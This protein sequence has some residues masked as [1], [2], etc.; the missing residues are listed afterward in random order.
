MSS[1]KIIREIRNL[2]KSINNQNKLIRQCFVKMS[3]SQKT[4]ELRIIL[5]ILFTD[6]PPVIENDVINRLTDKT[7]L[8]RLETRYD[9]FINKH[10]EALCFH[11]LID[12]VFDVRDSILLR[13][14]RV[15]RS[16]K[17]YAES[18]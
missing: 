14:G 2:T 10:Q 12:D 4:R 5:K 1:A 6:S 18:L 16:E 15:V 17:K 11:E 13:L 7:V 9:E 8:Q 3:E